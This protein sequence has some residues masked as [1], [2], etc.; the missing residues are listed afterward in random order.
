MCHILYK[1]S[2][3]IIVKRVGGITEMPYWIEIYKR[4]T[5]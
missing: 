4:M 2:M 3:F 5:T 1:I